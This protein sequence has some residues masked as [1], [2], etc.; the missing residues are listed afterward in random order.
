MFTLLIHF[1]PIPDSDFEE[2]ESGMDTI[3]KH[4]ESVDIKLLASSS[5]ALGSG[6]VIH[7]PSR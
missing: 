1:E 3:P 4:G 6:T 5:A 2:Y 7:A